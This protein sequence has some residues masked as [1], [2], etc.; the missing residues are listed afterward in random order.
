MA[1]HLVVFSGPFMD[2]GD[3]D[4]LKRLE[5]EDR[6]VKRFTPDFLSYLA[7]ADLSVSMAGYNTCMNVLS[8]G[9]PA[10]V[11]PFSQNREQ[12]FRAER[13]AQKASFKVLND[14]DLMPERMAMLIRK[15]LLHKELSNAMI[16]LQGSIYTAQWLNSRRIS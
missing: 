16:N 2:Q 6:M 3:F 11:W 14:E 5:S 10:I 15:R 8:A 1:L 12:R 13:L 9:T 4:R 7:A